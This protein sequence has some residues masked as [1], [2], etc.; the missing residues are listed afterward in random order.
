MSYY[1]DKSSYIRV[2]ALIYVRVQHV[3]FRHSA[4]KVTRQLSALGVWQ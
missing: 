1:D 3:G 4:G 2:R